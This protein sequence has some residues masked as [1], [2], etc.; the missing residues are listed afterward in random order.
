MV[1]HILISKNGSIVAKASEINNMWI[2]TRRYGVSGKKHHIL[3]SQ[4]HNDG[5]IC[6]GVF[7]TIDE[8][9]GYMK[10]LVEQLIET[11]P[12]NCYKA[13]IQSYLLIL[14]SSPCPYHPK[15]HIFLP[16]PF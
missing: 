15:T 12:A 10:G 2:Q 11:V 16:A 9:K 1:E 8:A 13:I 7:D 6:L 14:P 5:T 3:A 4:L